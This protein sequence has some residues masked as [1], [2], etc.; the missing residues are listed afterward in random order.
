MVRTHA[1]YTKNNLLKYEIFTS[2][3]IEKDG[4]YNYAPFRS[5]R[6]ERVCPVSLRHV[7]RSGDI[8]PILTDSRDVS[9]SVDMTDTSVIRNPRQRCWQTFQVSEILANAVGRLF[10]CQKSLPTR[11]AVCPG[12]RTASKKE[13]FSNYKLYKLDFYEYNKY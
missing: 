3:F 7:D 6:P 2:F 9:T 1:K 13:L 8:P 12:H 10:G 11:L 4:E 5:C